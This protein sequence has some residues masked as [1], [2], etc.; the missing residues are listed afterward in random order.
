MIMIMNTL[1]TI[2]VTITIMVITMGRITVTRTLDSMDIM[3][4]IMDTMTVVMG[5]LFKERVVEG[6]L[7]VE[8]VGEII[9]EVL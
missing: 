6:F 9:V 7:L 4:I 1:V 2:T 5:T 3:V 8:E